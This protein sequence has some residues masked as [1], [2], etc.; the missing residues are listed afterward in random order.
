MEESSTTNP[1]SAPVISISNLFSSFDSSMNISNLIHNL[2]NRSFSFDL[3][4]TS[5]LPATLLTS[6]KYDIANCVSNCSNHGLCKLSNGYKFICQCDMNFS[7]SKCDLDLRPCSNQPCLNYL[8]C[9]DI[10]NGTQ[11]N[12]NYQQFENYFSDFK[13]SCKDKFYGKRCEMIINLCENETCTNNGVCKILNENEMNETIKCE[14]FGKDQYEG[15]KCEIKTT[16]LVVR[17]TTVKSTYIIAIMI[18]ICLYGLMILSDVHNLFFKSK[19]CGKT[20]R[21]KLKV[22]AESRK[23]HYTP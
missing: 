22:R 11:F 1:L 4:S 5:S 13:C 6:A 7:G 3:S 12:T 10:Q 16:S 23:P 14:C 8:D 19:K 2:E 18:L 15:D 17:Q 21:R 9:N 20:V